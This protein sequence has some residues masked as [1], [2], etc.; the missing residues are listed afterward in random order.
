[1]I[2]KQLFVKPILSAIALLPLIA[3]HIWAKTS[4]A[5]VKA[6]LPKDLQWKANPKIEGI[7]SAIALGD[8]SSSQL[9]V[10]FGK[11][12][13][14]VVSPAHTHPDH[15]ITTVISGV[16]YYGVGEQFDRAKV[17]AYPAGSVVYTPLGVPH[18]MRAKSNTTVMQETGFGST[19]L[20]FSTAK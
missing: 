19:G 8:S 11:M 5:P 4:P 15:R 6:V 13:K 12:D 17:N 7:H 1:V 20:K 14:G 2:N 3:F 10:L 18:F 9:Y 16:M